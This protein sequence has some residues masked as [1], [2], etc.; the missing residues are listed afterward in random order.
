MVWSTACWDEILKEAFGGEKEMTVVLLRGS[1][2]DCPGEKSPA[3]EEVMGSLAHVPENPPK[4]L[5]GIAF[6][7]DLLILKNHIKSLNRFG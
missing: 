6:K 2:M 1:L 3:S 7:F 4:F 5:A